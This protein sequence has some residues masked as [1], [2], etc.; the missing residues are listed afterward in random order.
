MDITDKVVR[1]FWKYAQAGSED[2][3]W[4]WQGVINWLGLVDTLSRGAFSTTA[5]YGVVD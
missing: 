3:C 1:R 2:E 4:E 5:G